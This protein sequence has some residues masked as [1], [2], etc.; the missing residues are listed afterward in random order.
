MAIKSQ[1]F[2][3]QGGLYLVSYTI[4]D[5]MLKSLKVFA[6]YL[7]VPFICSCQTSVASQ[8][9]PNK[10]KIAYIQVAKTRHTRHARKQQHK[11]CKRLRKIQKKLEN[12]KNKK[13]TSGNNFY[14]Q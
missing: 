12:K 14:G 13:R 11:I 6:L 3:F 4:Y 9:F 8:G 7:L 2:L 5:T 10:K 1:V